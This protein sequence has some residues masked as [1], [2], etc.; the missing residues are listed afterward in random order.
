M[1]QVKDHH[2]FKVGGGLVHQ[3]DCQEDDYASKLI[4][5]YST[6]LQIPGLLISLIH[7]QEISPETITQQVK[8]ST[9]IT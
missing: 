8:L 1:F 7:P 2:G 9:F 4:I 6:Y 3:P 5:T